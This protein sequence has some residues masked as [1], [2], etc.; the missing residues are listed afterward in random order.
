MNDTRMQLEA[1]LSQPIS[2]AMWMLLEDTGAVARVERGEK[3]LEWLAALCP[4]IGVPRQVREPARML[5]TSKSHRRDARQMALSTVL[6]AEATKTPRVEEFRADVLK[7]ELLKSIDD[8]HIWAGEQSEA[9]G[10]PTIWLRDIP[11]PRSGVR[12]TRNEHTGRIG[13]DPAIRI[14]G[15]RGAERLL[16]RTV[17]VDFVDGSAQLYT[18]EHGTLERLRVV[19]EDLRQEYPWSAPAAA[20]FVLTGMV[21][22]VE[23]IKL[24]MQASKRIP[25]CRRIVL[26]ID[27]TVTPRQLGDYYRR[28]RRQLWDRRIRNQTEKHLRLAEFW[29]KGVS[30]ADVKPRMKEWNRKY[31]KKPNWRYGNVAMFRRDSLQAR[32]RLLGLHLSAPTP[33][34]YAAF[35]DTGYMEDDAK[36][37][38]W[39]FNEPGRK[40]VGDTSPRE[41]RRR[42]AKR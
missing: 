25:G 3:D 29:A 30:E 9:D 27:P 41:R 19:V 36:T 15:E 40:R 20:L 2:D 22:A 4:R 1:R 14:A 12:L 32:K 23:P 38:G 7:G 42:P 33:D 28:T 17:P 37:G 13:T 35:A 24:R 21:P 18:T 26:E 31:V 10:P 11:V 6:A 34:E 8:A 39:P 5:P 16:V